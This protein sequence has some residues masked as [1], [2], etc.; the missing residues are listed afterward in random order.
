LPGLSLPRQ[1]LK[2]RGFTL[3]EIVVA[4]AVMSLCITAILQSFV[5]VTG[6][7]R[8]ASDYYR[9]L[10]IAETRMALLVTQKDPRKSDR[11]DIDEVYRWETRVEQY[12][13][14]SDD[15]L[16][17]G[18]P[19]EALDNALMPYHFHVQV[20]WGDGKER[21]VELSTIRLGAGL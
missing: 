1:S 14:E 19:F 5:G 15:P 16:S 7:T 18:S 17:A 4:L 8:V 2:A 10:Q 6:S 13:P 11:G 21:S 12:V 3:L 20:T 9:A